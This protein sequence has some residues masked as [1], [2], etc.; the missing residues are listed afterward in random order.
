MFNLLITL[1][2]ILGSI[3]NAN[4]QIESNIEN[5]E[6]RGE[7]KVLCESTKVQKET[8]ELEREKYRDHKKQV[9]AATDLANQDAR[10]E[11]ASR[12]AEEV[13]SFTCKAYGRMC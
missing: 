13:K 12:H 9:K 3:A 11:A 6:C 1:V 4:A 2:I 8:L 5:F 7:D 10:K